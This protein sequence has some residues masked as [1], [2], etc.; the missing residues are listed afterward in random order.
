MENEWEKPNEN[1][2][3]IRKKKQ[4]PNSYRHRTECMRECMHHQRN[5]NWI[6]AFI[7]WYV[8][9]TMNGALHKI[10]AHIIAV[11]QFKNEQTNHCNYVQ[12]QCNTCVKAQFIS[13]I[14]RTLCSECIIHTM[15]KMMLPQPFHFETTRETERAKKK[16]QRTFKNHNRIII[17]YYTI[18][19]RNK[20]NQSV[21]K[22]KCNAMP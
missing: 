13:N 16:Q 10:D 6:S 1:K 2:N 19:T 7:W 4:P 15:I 9:L 20:P 17:S 12:Q 3:K 5:S 14:N 21:N 11:S 22:I 18:G 8:L